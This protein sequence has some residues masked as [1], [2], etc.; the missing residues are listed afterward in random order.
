VADRT[1]VRSND[2]GAPG[3]RSLV[4]LVDLSGVVMLG[5]PVPQVGAATAGPISAE[6]ATRRVHGQPAGPPPGGAGGA[7]GLTPGP[8]GNPAVRLVAA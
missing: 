3:V 2:L 4:D 1:A 8:S 5:L 7:I 6:L